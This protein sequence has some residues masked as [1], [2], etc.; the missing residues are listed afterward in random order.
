MRTKR[1]KFI[2]AVLLPLQYLG[3]L[4]LRQFPEFVETVYSNGI[5]PFFAT[6]LR[7]TFGWVPFSVGDLLYLLLGVYLVRWCF[8]NYKRIV[9][10]P[11]G[12]LLDILS[13]ISVIY[14]VFNLMWGIN[15]YRTPLYKSMELDRDYTTEQLIDIT[16]QL[17]EKAN[18]MHRQLGYADSTK[19]E[20]PYSQKEIFQSSLA[21]YTA[22]EKI[23]PEFSYR[24]LSL[25]NS[26]WSL[27]LTYMGYSGYYNPLTGEAQVNNLIKTY[28]FP[29][30]AAHEQAHQIGYAAENEANFIATLATIHN[31]DLFIQY[32]GYIFVLRYCINELARRDMDTYH[33]LLP[34]VNYGILE[35]YREM[36]EFWA[37]YEN[38]LEDVSKLFWD[39]FLK[40]NN[41]QQGIM[42]YS[43]MV[44]LVVNY[45]EKHP[46]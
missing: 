1:T 24:S 12:L 27:G 31:P 2:L 36:R 35:S 37:S 15:Y 45:F 6:I 39:Q 25:K 26:G 4:L 34:T 40:A 16:E 21:G 19:I 18:T 38:P 22:L 17:I 3:L 44:A 9:K 32:T 42:S 41:Q 30:V 33:R 13:S 14:F 28:K 5:F 10:G 46:F 23:H 29:V 7:Y 11:R 20:L 43:Y 8:K